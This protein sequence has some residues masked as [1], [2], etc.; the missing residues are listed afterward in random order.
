MGLWSSSKGKPDPKF[1]DRECKG[2]KIQEELG[3]CGAPTPNP[4]FCTPAF[5]IPVDS[6]LGMRCAIPG[7]PVFQHIFHR[8]PIYKWDNTGKGKLRLDQRAKSAWNPWD[9]GCSG[10]QIPNPEDPLHIPNSR[11]ERSFPPS[12]LDLHWNLGFTNQSRRKTQT[13]NWEGW[14]IR[15]IL[16]EALVT[17]RFPGGIPQQ[18]S[19]VFGSRRRPG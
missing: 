18:G 16:V 2:L 1:H 12:S 10:Q 17:R 9:F 5:P 11:M 7:I 8:F 13:K 3:F 15:N 6:A 19:G 14:K 4:R